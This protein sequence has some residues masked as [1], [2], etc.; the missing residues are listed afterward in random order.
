MNTII[1][2]TI[3]LFVFVSYGAKAQLT[4][5]N[6][7]SG[8][9]TGGIIGDNQDCVLMESNGRWNDRGCLTAGSLNYACYNG[10][11]WAIS[12]GTGDW[13]TG[14]NHGQCQNLG[15]DFYFA[16]PFNAYENQRLLEAK[17]QAGVG[18][19]WINIE[20]ATSEGNFISN[21][22]YRNAVAPPYITRWAGADPNNF[23]EPDDGGPNGSNDCVAMDRNGYW[24][25]RDCSENHR[26][27]CS[28]PGSSWVISSVT[29][30]ITELYSGE[31]ACRQSNSLYTFEAPTS[32]N[33]NA[34]ASSAVRSGMSTNE[35]IWINVN[36]LL[37]EDVFC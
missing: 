20:D 31:K 30:P 11:A 24:H 33:G 19:I 16:A 26:F 37:Q 6:W 25:D 7:Q 36:D 8:Q 35:L 17:N 9:P 18:D 32:D 14:D 4:Y 23:D 34:G 22:N 13:V 21:G 29:S 3:F 5:T 10:F 27:L 28:N 2:L 12:G 1:K 15:A